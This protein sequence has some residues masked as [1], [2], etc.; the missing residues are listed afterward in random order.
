MEAL[1][2]YRDVG[3]EASRVH[4]SIINASENFKQSP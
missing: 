3:G 2:R 1:S 4:A